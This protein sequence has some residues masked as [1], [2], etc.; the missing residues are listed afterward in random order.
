MPYKKEYC[1]ALKKKLESLSFEGRLNMIAFDI[2]KNTTTRQRQ[3]LM[4]TLV[5]GNIEQSDKDEIGNTST[6]NMMT[7]YDALCSTETYIND[8]C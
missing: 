7:L 1:I 3:R 6:P 5:S 8:S 2:N 4:K